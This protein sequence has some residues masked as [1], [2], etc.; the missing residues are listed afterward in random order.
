MKIFLSF[1]AACAGQ[2]CPNLRVNLNSENA[3]V[4]NKCSR[5][6]NSKCDIKCAYPYELRVRDDRR[7]FF[8]RRELLC[9]LAENNSENLFGIYV[10]NYV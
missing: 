6:E 3:K 5:T 2:Q 8:G 4:F 1:L 9:R 7:R 10:A